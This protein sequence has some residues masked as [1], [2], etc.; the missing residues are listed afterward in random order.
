MELVR[1]SDVL[2]TISLVDY[3]W[4]RCPQ[5]HGRISRP[6][7]CFVV[8]RSVFYDIW[9]QCVSFE[10]NNSRT[11]A[12]AI[13]RAFSF[14]LHIVPLLTAPGFQSTWGKFFKYFPLKMW[15]LI[16]L[17]IF[18]L[19]SLI[20]GVAQNPTTLIVGRAI[21]GLGAAGVAVGLFTMLGFAVPPEE[22][23]QI[24]GY[25]GATYGIGAVLGPLIGGAFTNSVTWRWVIHVFTSML[26]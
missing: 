9:R 15:F 13:C 5:N 2:L 19:G 26:V 4:Y 20:C 17:F 16:A 24:I 25:T 12:N 23:P 21:A 8:W 7:E 10:V 22:R 6:E 3:P 14:K 1:L 18:E 11:N